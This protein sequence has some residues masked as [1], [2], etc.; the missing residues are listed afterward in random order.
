MNFELPTTY[1]KSAGFT[2]IEIITGLAV[3]GFVTVLVASVYLAHF[4]LSSNQNTA[5]DT[6]TQNK[7]A[8]DEMTNQIRQ[9]QAIVS[10]CSSC[11]GDTTGANILI[12]QL[13]PLD[14]SN[15]PKDPMGINYDY[16]EY[17][18]DSVDPTKLIKKTFPDPTSTRKSGTKIVA[19]GVST[20]TFAY[21]NGNPTQALE[22][23]TTI[24]TTGTSNGKTQ[25]INQSEKAILRNK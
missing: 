11:A 17:R 23:T 1:S 10:T 4:R 6:S 25:T 2:L 15:D 16:V 8:F 7:L 3:T 21:D 5:I 22:V 12:L 14:A 24:A 19:T 13:W 18:L 20:L 9:A